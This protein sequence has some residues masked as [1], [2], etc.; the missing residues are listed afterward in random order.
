MEQGYLHESRHLI[1]WPASRVRAC[2]A[3]TKSIVLTHILGTPAPHLGELSSSVLGVVRIHTPSGARCRCEGFPGAW[4]Q[5]L[6]RVAGF[7][8]DFQK[9]FKRHLKGPGNQ[10]ME[11]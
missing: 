10:R 5:S 4:E 3:D 7:S 6:S 2:E 8:F 11:E 1:L 9:T